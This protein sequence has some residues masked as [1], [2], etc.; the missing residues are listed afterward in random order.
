MDFFFFFFFC[1]C[2]CCCCFVCLFVFCGKEGG[3]QGSTR[4]KPS[5]MM[6]LVGCLTS[7]QHASV[8]QRR[9]CSHHFTCCHTETEVADQ[10]SYLT[11]SQYTDTE[12]TSLSTDPYNVRRLAGKPLECQFLITGMTRPGASGNR[13]PDLSLSRRTP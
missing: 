6:L 3:R 4:T 7:Q 1:C 2:C 12:P 8:P 11:Q 13:T 9:I 10:A 5:T